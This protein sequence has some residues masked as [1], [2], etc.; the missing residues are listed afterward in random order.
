MHSDHNHLF[1]PTRVS[2]DFL[3]TSA[4]LYNLVRKQGYKD[5]VLD[6]SA[7]EF[8]SP[9]YMLP[10]ITTARSY[11]RDGV[12]FDFILPS[13]RRSAAMMKDTNWIHIVSPESHPPSDKINRS[14]LPARQFVDSKEHFLSI[15]DTMN[16]ILDT[17]SEFQ[18]DNFKALEWAL[19]E[20]T[21]NVLNHAESPIGGI[22]QVN[23]Y[24]KKGIIEFLV[25]D[26]GIG[27][28]KSLR[29]GRPDIKDDPSALRAAIDEGVT[30]NKQTNQGNGLFGTYKCCFVSGGEF[31]ILSGN[32]SLVWRKNSLNVSRSPIPYTGTFVRAVIA[33]RYDRLLDEALVFK[34]RHHK[35]E[36]DFIE[37]KYVSEDNKIVFRL[38]E[39]LES[40][41][42][43]ESGKYASNK[44]SNLTESYRI[45]IVF[46]F[47]GVN[48]ISSSFADEV[49]GKLFVAIG[50][51]NFAQL[52]S[53]INIDVTVKGLI[54]RAIGQRMR[55]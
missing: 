43:R 7:S 28:P 16:F 25:C 12:D 6:F 38:N 48:L 31:D 40:F 54:D 20:V 49:F 13:D 14:N 44:I 5:I 2:G 3:P 19:N 11:R 51:L 9:S 27:I 30:R 10:L 26:A 42:T 50:P 36:Y 1:F 24:P 55:Q 18:R 46:D 33:Y 32:V 53:F 41:G 17:T 45:P 37:R 34:G 21:D 15:D 4:A 29:S 22:M 52:C 23:T 8:L 47:E 39:H 35:P